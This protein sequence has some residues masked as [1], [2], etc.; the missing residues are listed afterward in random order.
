MRESKIAAVNVAPSSDNGHFVHPENETVQVINL[1]EVTETFF[2]NGPSQL[3]TANH[4]TLV[5]NE[6][7]LITCQMDFDAFEQVHRKSKD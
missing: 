2:V 5:Q 1:N 6:E 4:T 3:V 7:V